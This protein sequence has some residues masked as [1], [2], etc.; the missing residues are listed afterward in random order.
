MDE[1]ICSR[2]K[3]V[4][5]LAAFK[6]KGAQGWQAYC[7]ACQAAYRQQH[8]RAHKEK[9]IAKAKRSAAARRELVRETI[10][11]AK[12]GKTCADCGAAYPPWVLQF[13]HLDDS[14]KQ[15]AV[16]NMAGHGLSVTRVVREIAKCEIV[17][18][19]CHADRTHRRRIAG[20]PQR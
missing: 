8:Y 13:D 14:E 2:C 1:R 9:Y 12:Q 5:P 10:Q 3:V 11:K 7:V 20:V 19:N 15:A 17:C 16:A 6:A 4:K 18:A